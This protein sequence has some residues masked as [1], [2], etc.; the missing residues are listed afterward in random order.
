M[1]LLSAIPNAL[2]TLL[3]QLIALLG[4]EPA[5]F[6]QFSII[7]LVFAFGSSLSLSVVSEPWIRG[8][9]E[10]DRGRAWPA[11]SIVSLAVSLLAGVIALGASYFLD[12]S[13]LNALI[14]ASAVT[15]AVLRLNIRYFAVEQRE[16]KLVLGGDFGLMIPIAL[17]F[18]LIMAGLVQPDAQFV[19]STWA[20]G[21][22][23]SL[24]FGRVRSAGTMLDLRRW[25]ETHRNHISVL[26]KDSLILDLSAIGTPLLLLPT[27]GPMN[28][29]IYRAVSNVA[30]PVRLILSPLR[31]I[32][33]GRGRM[34]ATRYMEIGFVAA[35][36]LTFG[37][38]AAAVLLLVSKYSPQLGTIG[39]LASWPAPVGLFV[40]ANFFGHYFYLI[41][42]GRS[43]VRNLMLGR[44]VQT[45]T[46]ILPPLLG[47]WIWG[48]SAAI[49]G[50]AIGVLVSALYWAILA[51]FGADI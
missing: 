44:Y 32:I 50:I 21:G 14:A 38:V 22:A 1:W 15:F 8:I 28:F 16:A 33:V 12:F 19:L 42:R 34:S 47:G 37:I 11:Y 26:I 49:W 4:L 17:G 48:L 9:N 13:A 27:L 35:I 7:Y 3:L 39:P 45:A 46:T 31:P 5:M 25:F 41:A 24:L 30:A 51:K 18:L 23:I 10:L 36:A 20:I 40:A 43:G 29:G 6:T 2:G